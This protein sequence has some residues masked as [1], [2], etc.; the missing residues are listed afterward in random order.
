[1]DRSHDSQLS[2]VPTI[3]EQKLTFKINLQ[4]KDANKN[5]MHSNLAGQRTPHPAPKLNLTKYSIV[6][7]FFLKIVMYVYYDSVNIQTFEIY[8][9]P[10]NV[11]Q[12][13]KKKPS[14]L[15]IFEQFKQF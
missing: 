6:S 3:Y 1:M 11:T 9:D 4:S 15:E 12:W 2:C 10:Y 8:K 5:F 7:C 13:F 14:A